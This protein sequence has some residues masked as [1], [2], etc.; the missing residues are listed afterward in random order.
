MT[1]IRTEP[2]ALRRLWIGIAFALS[3]PERL[4]RTVAGFVGMVLLFAARLLPRPLRET[5]IYRVIAMRWIRILC[6]D[7]GNAGRFPKQQQLDKKTALRLGISSAVDNLFLLTLHA[8]PL[9][10]LFAASDVAN[11]AKTLVNEVNEELKKA[12]VLK[13]GDRL[14]K[15]DELFG[16]VATISEKASGVVDLP[17]IDAK[18][19]KQ[20]VQTISDELATTGKSAVGD[21]AQFDRMAQD[22][23]ELAHRTKRPVL[24]VLT[25]LATSSA[26]K[27]GTLF[28]G[29][30]VAASASLKAVHKHISQPTIDDYAAQLAEIREKGVFK[31]ILE[32]LAPH[33]RSTDSNFSTDLVTWTEKILG[34]RERHA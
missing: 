22:V 21:V 4:I 27:A 11:G 13:E 17:P 14:D 23:L 12:G 28:T 32:N 10:I 25:S 33:I 34:V 9:W 15:V 6:D 31:S 7:L 16:A 1:T 8:S 24:E 26:E 29:S 2:T 20:Q 19:L 5:R 30:G 18:D 3:L